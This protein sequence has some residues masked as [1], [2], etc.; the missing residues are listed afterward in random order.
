MKGLI[1]RTVR[2][3]WVCFGRTFVNLILKISV[4][5]YGLFTYQMQNQSIF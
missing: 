3:V 4:L 5:R 2:W 1:F